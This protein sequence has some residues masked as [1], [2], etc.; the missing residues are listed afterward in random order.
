MKSYIVYNENGQEVAIIKASGH[1]A[2]EKKAQKKYG[3]R[4]SVAYTEV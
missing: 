3:N 1:N 4:A 2:A